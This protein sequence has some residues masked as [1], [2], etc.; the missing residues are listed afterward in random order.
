MA[1]HWGAGRS[2]DTLCD[3]V[4]EGAIRRRVV[5]G[6][7]QDSPWRTGLLRWANRRD[8]G[9]H[10]LH[11]P[12]QIANLEAGGH[13]GA[14]HRTGIFF[15]ADRLLDVWMLLRARVSLS[16]GDPFSADAG[17]AWC[18]RASHGD[19]R[20]AAQPRFLLFPGVAVSAAEIRRPDIRDVPDRVRVHSVV[21]GIFPGRLSGALSGWMGN[22]G[23]GVEHRNS[24]G[25]VVVVLSASASA[26]QASLTAKQPM[27]ENRE[28]QLAAGPLLLLAGATATG[29]SA[30]ALRLAEELNGEIV[31]ADSMQVY[32]GLDI[33][34]AKPSREEQRR[35]P[36]HLIDVVDVRER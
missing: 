11:S 16:L 12:T 27:A 30:V 31:S 22:A 3:F 7:F 35:V 19:L 20:F 6:D 32:R 29:K 10:D 33:G 1:H 23:P 2:A 36:H 13:T 14:E 4:L 8:A 28:I 25:G 9:V 17:D 18:S 5:A 26:A 34:T 15:R 21:C 24:G